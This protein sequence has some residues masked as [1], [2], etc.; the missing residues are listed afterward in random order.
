LT[1]GCGYFSP[2]CSRGLPLHP[3]RP[4]LDAPARSRS[5]Q[6]PHHSERCANRRAA[7]YGSPHSILMSQPNAVSLPS[8]ASRMSCAKPHDRSS[9]GQPECAAASGLPNDKPR[10]PHRRTYAVVGPLA[11]EV[12]HRSR[13]RLDAP[14]S[15]RDPTR[16]RHAESRALLGTNER[17][18]AE[19]A[20]RKKLSSSDNPSK[21]VNGSAPMRSSTETR[22]S[23]QWKPAGSTSSAPSCAWSSATP[24]HGRGIEGAYSDRSQKFPDDQV[25]LT[26]FLQITHRQSYRIG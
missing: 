10:R 24:G 13:S 12:S 25:D 7:V 20:R 9:R 17:M 2:S 6:R 21:H 15:T 1:T 3:V 18:P 22:C 14:A 8:S 11:D 26:I 5:R 4:K 16:R 19:R 23:N